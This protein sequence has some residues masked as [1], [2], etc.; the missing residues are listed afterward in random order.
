[1]KKTKEQLREKV[2]KILKDNKMTNKIPK[3]NLKCCICGVEQSIRTN[4]KSLYTEKVIKEWKCLT[5]SSKNKP[6]KIT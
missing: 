3:I 6:F 1:M 4:N 5:C 2:K